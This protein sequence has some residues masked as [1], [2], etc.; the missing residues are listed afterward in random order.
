ENSIMMGFDKYGDDEFIVTGY[1]IDKDKYS[2]R[3]TARLNSNPSGIE[4][5][6]D[7]GII[8]NQYDDQ[9]YIESQSTGLDIQIYDVLGKVYLAK[10]TDQQTTFVELESIPSGF[11]I[12]SVSSGTSRRVYKIIK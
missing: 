12:V 3:Y 4:E 1:Y 9:L 6:R 7:E 2:Y 5:T 8:I 10:R 11:Y